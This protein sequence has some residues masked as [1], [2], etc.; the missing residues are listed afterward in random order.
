[1][2]TFLILVA[3]LNVCSSCERIRLVTD[4]LSI[5]FSK[6]LST[7]KSGRTSY[8]SDDGTKTQYL[9]HVMATGRWV[10]NDVIDVEDRA[11]AFVGK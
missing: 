2:K 3:I 6:H 4:L 5:E 10:V 7:G 11:N 8:I 1:M 9:Y